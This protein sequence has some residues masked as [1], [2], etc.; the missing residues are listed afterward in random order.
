PSAVAMIDMQRMARWFPAEGAAALLPGQQALVFREGKAV[1]PPEV[2]VAPA[3][4][5]PSGQ[6]AFAVIGVGGPAQP[7]PRV[8]LGLVGLAPGIDRGE[9]AFAIF[10]IFGIALALALRSL[11]HSGQARQRAMPGARRR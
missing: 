11:G 7:P 1:E 10:G 2:V 8:D 6:L 5:A 3:T 9:P 4:A